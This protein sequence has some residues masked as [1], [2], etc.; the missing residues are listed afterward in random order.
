MICGIGVDIAEV[1]VLAECIRESGDAYIKR[2]FTQVEIEYCDSVTNSMESYAARLAAK[3]AGMKA[4]ATGWDQGV[5]WHDFEI[6][7]EPSG[8]PTMLVHGKAAE[9]I[10]A[11][12]VSS[13]W[14][15]LSHASGYAI[16][17]VLLERN[18]VP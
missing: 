5:D 16:A 18:T 14:V 1:A 2:I 13:I 8:Q 6:V 12:S 4:L 10:K 7:N 15:S 17:Q 9:L 3:E 11:L